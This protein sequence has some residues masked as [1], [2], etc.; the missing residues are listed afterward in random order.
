MAGALDPKVKAYFQIGDDKFPLPRPSGDEQELYPGGEIITNA[1][2]G[3]SPSLISGDSSVVDE[4]RISV[5]PSSDWQAGQ[6]YRFVDEQEGASG[7]AYGTLDTRYPNMAVLP[8]KPVDLGL[9]PSGANPSNIRFMYH[10]NIGTGAGY[11]LALSVYVSLDGDNYYR[12]AAGVWQPMTVISGAVGST[13][14]GATF[15]PT[16][17]GIDDLLI[18]T[19]KGLFSVTTG[20]IFGAWV[21]ELLTTLGAFGPV[22]HDEKVYFLNRDDYKMYWAATLSSTLADWSVSSDPLQLRGGENVIKLYEATNRNGVKSVHALT[23]QRIVAYDDDDFWV[24]V[25]DNRPVDTNQYR[26]DA[27]VWRTDQV[28]YYTFGE[29]GGSAVFQVTGNTFAN[30]SPN[31]RGGYPLAQRRLIRHL[32][33]GLNWLYALGAQTIDE[34]YIGISGGPTAPAVPGWVMAWNG[35]G[36]HTLAE[37]ESSSEPIVAV[38][39]IQNQV[40]YLQY[41]SSVSRYRVYTLYV[42]EF[43]NLP[44]DDDARQYATGTFILRS[45]EIDNGLEDT[46]KTCRHFSVQ[47]ETQDGLPGMP[48]DHSAQLW[49]SF[50]GGAFAQYGATMTDLSEYPNIITLPSD[51][52]QSGIPYKKF[53]W[54]IRVTKDVGADAFVTPI[55]RWVNEAYTLSPDIYDGFQVTIDLSEERFDGVNR[56]RFFNK[57]RRYLLRKLREIAASKAHQTV[58]WGN[59]TGL[60][61]EIPAAQLR[62]NARENP[63][64][65]FGQYT[66]TGQDVS[67][68]ASG[69]PPGAVTL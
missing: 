51:S 29:S 7:Y 62:I 11:L 52:D 24:E 4:R 65:N 15:I 30:V 50:D 63:G 25:F 31:K 49:V 26:S 6:G 13:L 43:G 9:L 58:R 2:E 34:D 3:F 35:N 33:P 47:F 18:A 38:S 1:L 54:E 56:G 40:L 57:S 64:T 19:N 10:P 59:E 8:P 69:P 37:G 68:P 61:R 39:Y 28:T 45:G 53:Q 46:D 14:Y 41:D 5:H 44:Y 55:L 36:W 12:D 23:T 60:I 67:A 48:E 16:A 32:S 21:T 42:P 66:V 27:A 17:S 22:W 20:G